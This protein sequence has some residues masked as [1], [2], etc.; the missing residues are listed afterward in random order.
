MT[1]AYIIAE[2]GVNHNGSVAMAK[3]LI[4][5]AVKAGA[6]AVKFQSFKS[7]KGISRKAVKADYQ[8]R[9]TGEAESQLEMVKKLELSEEDHFVLFDYCKQNKIEFLSTP[10]DTDSVDLLTKLN[11]N[12]FKISSGEVINAPLLLYT[13]RKKKPIILSTGMCSIGDIEQ[14][15]YV[16]AFGY[17]NNDIERPSQT[18]FQLA[19]NSSEGQALL[20]KNVTLLHCTTEYPAPLEDVNLLSMDT[21]KAAFNLPI[22][23]SDHTTGINISL[24]AV[25]R[26]AAVIEKHITLDCNLPGPDHQASLEPDE[27]NNMVK[28]I[29]EIEMALGSYIKQCTPS[30]LKNKAIARKSLVAQKPI[31]KGELF[32]EDNLTAKRPG[33]GISP[34]LYW[35]YIGTAADKAYEE[36]D[37]I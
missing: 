25:A 14:A 3:Q 2:A 22:G 18:D 23:F 33:N 6:D 8:K 24:A 20:Q 21:L 28:G 31:E 5:V 10:F 17:L 13:A 9:L 26:G 34:M 12:K 16:L 32:S 15:L 11:V 29:R 4:D 37:L 1:K 36:D 7:E 30:E 27:L 19:Y 35:E